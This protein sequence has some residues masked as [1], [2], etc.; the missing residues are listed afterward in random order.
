MGKKVFFVDVQIYPL[1]Q[2]GSLGNKK[3]KNSEKK[4]SV[5]ETSLLTGS[6]SSR[7]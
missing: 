3:K 5:K 7:I 4:N 2:F 6:L 1:S